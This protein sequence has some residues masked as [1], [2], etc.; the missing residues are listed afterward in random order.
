MKGTQIVRLPDFQT[1]M[2]KLC[3][4]EELIAYLP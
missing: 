4:Q 1:L 2:H 3:P